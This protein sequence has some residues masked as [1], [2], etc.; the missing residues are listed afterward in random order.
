MGAH[1][2]FVSISILSTCSIFCVTASAATDSIYPHAA[3]FVAGGELAD[4]DGDGFLD[5]VAWSSTFSGARLSLGAGDGTFEFAATS[6]WGS[7]LGDHR[8]ADLNGD[9]HA[10]AFGTP[11]LAPGNTGANRLYVALGSATGL[12]SHVEID[13]GSATPKFTTAIDYDDDGDLDLLVKNWTG[14]YAFWRNDGGTTFVSVS[15]TLPAVGDLD[16]PLVADFDL[17]GRVD[18]ANN[19]SED[20]S[21]HLLRNVS[22]GVFTDIAVALPSGM[23]G[24][25]VITGDFDADGRPDL[26][27][28]SGSPNSVTLHFGRTSGGSPTFSSQ[29]AYGLETGTQGVEWSTSLSA[30]DI[31]EDGACDLAGFQ[32]TT[33]RVAFAETTA[34][35]LSVRT[36]RPSFAH[37]GAIGDFDSSFGVDLLQV[38]APFLFTCISSFL[39]ADPRVISTATG[40]TLVDAVVLLDVDSDGDLD[41]VT[42]SPSDD[43]LIVRRNDGSTISTTDEVLI[44]APAGIV[45]LLTI[46]HDDDGDLDIVAW[47]TTTAHVFRNDGASG[48]AAWTSAASVSG[49]GQATAGDFDGDGFA[50]LALATTSNIVIA[51]GSTTGYS[52]TSSFPTSL[53]YVRGI[54]TADVDHD[55]DL[56]L[57]TIENASATGTSSLVMYAGDGAGSFTLGPATSIGVGPLA[58]RLADFDSNSLFEA[59]VTSVD[60]ESLRTFEYGTTTGFV[61]DQNLALYSGEVPSPIGSGH[62]AI[63]DVDHDGLLDILATRPAGGVSVF[64]AVT[65]GVFETAGEYAVRGGDSIAAGD[66]NGDTYADLVSVGDADGEFYVAHAGA[67]VVTV[68][69]YGSG[70]AGTYGVPGIEILPTTSFGSFTGLKLTNGHPGLS[71]FLF[72]GST[73]ISLSFDLGTLLVSPV[74]TIPLPPYAGDGTLTLPFAIPQ[75]PGLSSF[76]ACFQAMFVDPGAAGSLHTAQT[77]GLLLTFD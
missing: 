51:R 10:D 36:D 27:T 8:V 2:S 43:A 25:S 42:D 21:L 37:G 55:G 67:K 13:T 17:D 77:S 72:I 5:T 57:V 52:T 41:A 56:D 64:L 23:T 31:N 28:R 46:D 49:N 3:S 71:P 70:K 65:A 61:E 1:H 6:T 76:Q 15:V 14:A 9:G 30:Y 32:G 63:I 54:D 20:T 75:L 12:G 4:V 68:T 69:N 74:V 18:L 53:Q 58:V 40:G 26:V 11:G 39:T 73:P 59:V 62:V 22:T 45:A 7:S 60:E 29:T 47:T 34:T 38:R 50:D 33:L 16:H 48:F 35:G 19:A 44:S 66:V 24:Q